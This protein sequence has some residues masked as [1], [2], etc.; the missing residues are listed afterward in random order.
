MD[1][2][3]CILQPVGWTHVGE[4]GELSPMG[5]TPHGRRWSVWGV[6]FLRRKEWQRQCV[7]NWLQLP[8]PILLC[9]S[10]GGGRENQSEVEPGKKSSG[11]VFSRC[12]FVSHYPTL[13]WLVI[14]SVYFSKLTL[15]FACYNNCWVISLCPYIEPW[16]FPYVFSPQSSWG[17]EC[18]SGIGGHLGQT[19]SA[20]YKISENNNTII[21]NSTQYILFYLS[22]TYVSNKIV[23]L[24]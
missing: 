13:I 21:L 9:H 1:Y 17:E 22:P 18:Q 2:F 23:D 14:S 12:R 16:T 20:H 4:D 3:K 8:F 7:M 19:G 6:F 24:T 11:E 15:R 10:G 5:G